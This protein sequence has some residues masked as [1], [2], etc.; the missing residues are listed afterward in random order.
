M[1]RRN[2]RA[3]SVLNKSLSFIHLS[4]AMPTTFQTS[5]D[6]NNEP[7]SPAVT[8]GK[9][10]FEQMTI[11]AAWLNYWRWLANFVICNR[12]QIMGEIF[13]WWDSQTW[14][15]VYW[16]YITL[17]HFLLRVGGEPRT[18]DFLVS[19]MYGASD[20]RLWDNYHWSSYNS[21]SQLGWVLEDFLTLKKRIIL[22]QKCRFLGK[23]PHCCGSFMGGISP[24][25]TNDGYYR[26][27]KSKPGS[28]VCKNIC[29]M[30]RIAETITGWKLVAFLCRCQTRIHGSLHS[31]PLGQSTSK[32]SPSN[33]S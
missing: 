10:T 13:L 1:F 26:R 12:L 19:S 20:P 21:L 29:S 7:P 6:M 23:R 8:F 24:G 30:S 9:T 17:V 18:F 32:N 31:P 27:S 5:V 4:L 28:I 25:A 3:G 16:K 22:K 15:D 11:R 33:A 2:P 14:T